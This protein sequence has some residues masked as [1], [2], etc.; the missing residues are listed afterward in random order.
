MDYI[1][2][3]Q[4]GSFAE[5]L[6]NSSNKDLRLYSIICFILKLEKCETEKDIEC[7]KIY[8]NMH[9]QLFYMSKNEMI[10]YILKENKNLTNEELP[11][12]VDYYKLDLGSDNINDLTL[13]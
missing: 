7:Q 10:R 5:F 9:Y 11:I 1:E 8:S 4:E 6:A 3:I 12:L 2:N 13:Y